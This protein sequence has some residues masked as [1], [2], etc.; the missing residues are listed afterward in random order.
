MIPDLTQVDRRQVRR[1]LKAIADGVPSDGL[2]SWVTVG[3]QKIR[4]TF[5]ENLNAVAEGSFVLRFLLGSPGSGKSHLLRV[6]AADAVAE[7]RGG[8][9]QHRAAPANR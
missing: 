6:L 1:F 2:T 3:E 8:D 5:A 7:K 9:Q 4:G